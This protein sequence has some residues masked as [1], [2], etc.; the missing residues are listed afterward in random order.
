MRRVVVS[1]ACCTAFIA[2]SVVAPVAGSSASPTTPA[3]T[4]QHQPVWSDPTPFISLQ[5]VT[6]TPPAPAAPVVVSPPP[7]VTNANSVNTPE[8]ACIRQ[9]ESGDN[10]ADTSGAYGILVDTWWSHSDPDVVDAWKAASGGA[11]YAVPGDAPPAV[12][13]AVALFLFAANGYRFG[14]TWNDYCTGT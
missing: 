2:L 7:P 1:I 4:H 12:Q 6:P 13:D 9:A 11:Y 14:G 3:P 10:Y 8:W 5:A